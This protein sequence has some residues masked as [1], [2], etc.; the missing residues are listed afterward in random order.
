MANNRLILVSA[1]A[2]SVIALASSCSKDSGD[3][4]GNGKSLSTGGSGNSLGTGGSGAG[5]VPNV[6]TGTGSVVPIT[7]EQVTNLQNLAC[8]AWAMEPEG[9]ASKLELVVDISSSM[10]QS[11][12]GINTTK[13]VATRDALAEAVPGVNGPGLGANTAVGLLY[14]PGLKVQNVPT[15]P[16]PDSTSCL[17]LSDS[18]PMAPMGDMSGAQRTAIF[19][20][21]MTVPLGQG[22]PTLDAYTYA[23]E[24]VVLAPAQQAFPGD[25]YILLITDGLPT[26]DLGCYNVNGSLDDSSVPSAPIVAKVADAMS[27]GVKTFIIGSPGSEEGKSWLSAAARAGGTGTAGCSDNGPTYCHMDMTTAPD[28]SV[29]LRNGLAQ[30]MH[31][32]SGCKYVVPT[33]STDGTQTV[34]PALISPIIQYSDGSSELATADSTGACAGEGYRLNSAT[35]LEFCPTTCARMQADGGAVIQ[36]LFGC[37]PEDTGIPL[38]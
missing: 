22:T 36:F 21:L 7:P 17:N 26:L 9:L 35:E 28:F 31:T 1:A 16:R 34:D 19:N 27:R 33:E 4:D 6:G 2:L 5:S 37:S 29:A 13:W 15:T 30:V 23:L 38:Q 3:D 8:A 10:N 18:I 25:P 11:A 14:F 12:N 32:V 20:S 24:N